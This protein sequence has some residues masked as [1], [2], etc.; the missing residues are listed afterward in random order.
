MDAI[1]LLKKDHQ[2][3]TKLFQ[4]YSS[5]KDKRGARQIVEKICSELTVHAQIEEEIF[6]PAVRGANRELE[7]KVEESI[8]EHARMKEQV[9]ALEAAQGEDVAG[10][11]SALQQDVEHHVTE[12]EGAMFPQVQQMIDA[13][14]RGALGQQLQERK[15]ELMGGG[16]RAPRRPPST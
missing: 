7:E 15:E 14:E 5:S 13:R 10:M 8:R 11:V 16:T 9:A 1:E 2:E 6:Y 3:V 12:E 4:R